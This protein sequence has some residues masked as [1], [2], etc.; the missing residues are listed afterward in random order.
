MYDFRITKR[1][2]WT[3]PCIGDASRN[4]VRYAKNIWIGDDVP[5]KAALALIRSRPTE[6]G[7]SVDDLANKAVVAPSRSRPTEVDI[8]DSHASVGHAHGPSFS[9][10]A[11]SMSQPHSELGSCEGCLAARV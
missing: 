3:I 8:N 1:I 6:L 7:T 2:V 11:Q 4:N 9:A 5:S 10:F